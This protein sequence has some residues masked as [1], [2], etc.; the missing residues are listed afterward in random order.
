[1][2]PIEPVAARAL[3]RGPGAAQVRDQVDRVV[4]R[5]DR[6]GRWVAATVRAPIGAARGVA[7]LPETASVGS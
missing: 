1:M 4:R 6:P 7:D 5:E 2:N 3:D